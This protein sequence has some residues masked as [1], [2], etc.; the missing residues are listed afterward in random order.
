MKILFS[1]G[2]LLLVSV[3][4]LR[5]YFIMPF[6]GS[7]R[8]ETI[9]IAYFLESNINLFRIIGLVVIVYP[10]L[11]LLQSKNRKIKIATV[12]GLG[13]WLGVGYLFNFRFLA[14]RMFYQP[15]NKIFFTADK[16]KISHKQLILGISINGEQKAYPIELIGYH[17]QVRDVVGG[18]SVMVTYCTVCRTGRAY[19]PEVKGQ[20][21]EFRLVGMDHFNAMFEDSRTKS[22]WRQVNGEAIAGPLKGEFITE[23]P[24][25]Q[26]RLD[27]WL[28]RYPASQIMQPDSLFNEEYKSLINYDEGKTKEGLQ[29]ADSLS[30]KDKSWVLGISMGM[31]SRAYDWHDL[32][33]L[34]IIND[35]ME[36]TPVLIA[37]E[38]DSVTFHAFGR[39]SLSFEYDPE[40]KI[41]N[42]VNTASS[43]SLGGECIDGVLKG[44]QLKT[45][46][47]YQEYWHSWKTFHPNT[48]EF[49]PE[50]KPSEKR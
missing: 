50:T 22:W 3:E 41:M 29:R 18:R 30:W 48:T 11:L 32:K 24:S 47:S 9:E 12:C 27:A 4:I 45:I 10:T 46:Q 43:W 25:E 5:V 34:K 44:T 38:S 2:I 8:N 39:D 16:S 1:A 20:P 28:T 6:P 15:Q 31:Y 14:E 33:K 13:V 19:A 37:L 36:K 35:E 21:E 26:M 42:D 40:K 17:H 23:I 49:H 7:Q